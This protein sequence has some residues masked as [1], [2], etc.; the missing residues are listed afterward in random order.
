V[1]VVWDPAAGGAGGE[2][3]LNTEAGRCC[4][5]LA[6]VDAGAARMASGPAGMIRGMTLAEL[7]CGRRRTSPDGAG[8]GGAG[9]GGR[10]RVGGAPSRSGGAVAFKLEG[11][12][13]VAG[14][15]ARVGT[16]V[17]WGRR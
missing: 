14:A 17:R 8:A 6:I 11:P 9:A 3:R 16:P 2:V 12:R 1:S 13:R 7:V 5:P 15:P 10:R 4:R